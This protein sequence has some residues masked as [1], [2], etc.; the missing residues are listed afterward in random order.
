MLKKP[1]RRYEGYMIKPYAP[2][3]STLLKLGPRNYDITKFTK[4]ILNNVFHK[5]TTA[6]T[7]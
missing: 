2:N 7:M 5:K 3:T 4:K 1:S 6:K